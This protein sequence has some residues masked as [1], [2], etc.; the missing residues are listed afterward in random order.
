MSDT[1]PLTL[2]AVDDETEAAPETPDGPRRGRP[3]VTPP[4]W[5][6]LM[7]QSEGNLSR[8]SHVK[9]FHMMT[10][11]GVLDIGGEFTYVT[12]D[13]ATGANPRYEILAE[14]GQLA[15]PAT[16]REVAAQV[17]KRRIKV[18]DAI[19]LIRTFRNGRAAPGDADA[20]AGEIARVVR[21]YKLRHPETT[22]DQVHEALGTAGEDYPQSWPEDDEPGDDARPFPL[23]PVVYAD[24]P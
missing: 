8:R 17:C 12:G 20:L 2:D 11:I 4:E 19:A 22:N 15:D 16:I 7:E 9:R 6:D 5:D 10:A 24:N 23:A 13:E 1:I 18:K 21:N 3:R 14:L